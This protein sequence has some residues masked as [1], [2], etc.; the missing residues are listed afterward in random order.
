MK[1]QTW[2]DIINTCIAIATLVATIYIGSTSNEIANNIVER[3]KKQVSKDYLSNFHSTIMNSQDFYQIWR[4]I[5]EEKKIPNDA[6]K[7]SFIDNFE[8]I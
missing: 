8:G 6:K 5:D 2:L 3:D 7:A 4:Y 1:K